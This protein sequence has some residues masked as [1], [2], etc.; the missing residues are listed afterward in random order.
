MESIKIVTLLKQLFK[1]LFYTVFIVLIILVL[2]D[3]PKYQS[4]SLAT[5][6]D[7]RVVVRPYGQDQYVAIAVPVKAP[8][9]VFDK[10]LMDPIGF[11]GESGLSING[12]KVTIA[13]TAP[14]ALFLL[15]Q[16]E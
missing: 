15:R 10:A 11:V 6:N 13:S 9:Y 7:Y 16:S 3:R 1:H 4:N 5:L 2:T 14:E 8:Q 12:V